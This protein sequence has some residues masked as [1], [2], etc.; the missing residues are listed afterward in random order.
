M[1]DGGRVSG[2]KMCPCK[3]SGAGHDLA[4]L[5]TARRAVWLECSDGRGRRERP[6]SREQRVAKV[7]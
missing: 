5:E 3:S 7:T 2:A 4:Y 6:E 1:D